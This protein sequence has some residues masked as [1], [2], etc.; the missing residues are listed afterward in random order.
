VLLAHAL[1]GELWLGHDGNKPADVDGE[2][3]ADEVVHLEEETESA[4]LHLVD[5]REELD[6]LVHTLHAEVD[7]HQPIDVLHV[8]GSVLVRGGSWVIL[9]L[10]EV[11]G[12]EFEDEG[13]DS[14]ADG[15][16]HG[17]E[18]V[19]DV[20]VVVSTQFDPDAFITSEKLALGGSRCILQLVVG[21]ATLD[22]VDVQ[23]HFNSV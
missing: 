9:S 13:H 15:D 18:L 2:A 12:L 1:G 20:E 4:L 14:E 6:E 8:S 16:A 5:L 3:N 19:Q 17:D 22:V 11:H 7:E 23:I 21:L 10:D